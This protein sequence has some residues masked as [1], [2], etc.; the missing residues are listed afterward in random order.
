MKKIILSSVFLASFSVI[1]ADANPA[2]SLIRAVKLLSL[3]DLTCKSVASCQAVA[4]GSR[5]CGGPASYVIASVLNP[6]YEE[7]TYLAQA[8]EVKGELFNQDNGVISICVMA[9]MPKV[10]CV[11]NLCV[12]K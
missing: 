11:K 12:N 6:N 7:L 3:A 10:S 1:A 5:A 8:S 4:V 9:P 2:T